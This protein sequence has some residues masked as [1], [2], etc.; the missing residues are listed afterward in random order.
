[1][2]C[3][4]LISAVVMGVN[5]KA[6]NVLAEV[7]STTDEYWK[8][9]SSSGAAVT[10]QGATITF[11]S[12]KEGDS[13]TYSTSVDSSGNW[14]LSGVSAGKYRITGSQTGWTFIPM[15]IEISGFMSEVTTDVLAYPT[16]TGNPLMIIVRW[17]NE[18]IDIDAHTIID[19]DTD[20][21]NYTG[22]DYVYHAKKT[23]TLPAAGT[24]VL[25][26]DVKFVTST[27]ST[28]NGYPVETVRVISNPFGSG[29][30]GQLR[31]YLQS[32]SYYNGLSQVTSN[33]TLTGD[34]TATYTGRADAT[35]YV[36][37]GTEH[38]GTWTMPIDTAEKTL[39]ILKIDVSGTSTATNYEI[40]SFGNEG[41][42]PKSIGAVSLS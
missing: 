9:E 38:Y 30:T 6:V 32:Y 3:D 8:G 21:T 36:M 25:D 17:N 37:L 27:S 10:L 7:T 4:W 15:D 23:N 26:R 11:T 33:T 41:N 20:L 5:G 39:G 29:F 42:T 28:L 13:T 18:L 16:P 1:M 34:P 31:Y 40:K 24:V 14:Y 19:L 12:L 2:S 22:G 35:V